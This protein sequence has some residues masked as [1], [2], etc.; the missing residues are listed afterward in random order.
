LTRVER[1]S[2]AVLRVAGVDDFP[3]D[4]DPPRGLESGAPSRGI[5]T[6]GKSNP[7]ADSVADSGA[8]SVA[9]SLDE[10]GVEPQSVRLWSMVR[11]ARPDDDLVDVSFVTAAGSRHTF[12][13]REV[14]ILSIAKS[15]LD[16]RPSGCGGGDQAH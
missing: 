2:G 1:A 10:R 6:K 16:R 4:A 5:V 7:V 11:G 15:V 8:E 9:D 12:R 3:L 14:D 13:L